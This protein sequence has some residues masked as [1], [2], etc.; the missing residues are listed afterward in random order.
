VSDVFL[1][2]SQRDAGVAK[3]VAKALQHAGFNVWWDVNLHAGD[4]FRQEIAKE[5]SVAKCVV[6]LWSRNSVNSA[7]VIDEAEDGRRRGV[8]VQSILD[9]VEPPVGFR[10]VQWANLVPLSRG[11]REVPGLADLVSGVAR[12]APRLDPSAIFETS[13]VGTLAESSSIGQL[14]KGGLMV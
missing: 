5:L 12:H 13:A 4:N 8:L 2:Y 11:A 9:N 14:K 3:R 6:V 10:G 1:S 7:Y